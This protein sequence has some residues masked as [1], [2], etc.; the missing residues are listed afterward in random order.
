MKKKGAKKITDKKTISEKIIKEPEKVKADN[1]SK[2]YQEVY[3]NI[4]KEHEYLQITKPKTNQKDESDN[5]D[6]NLFKIEEKDFEQ[7]NNYYQNDP[8]KEENIINLNNKNEK[9]EDNNIND[10]QDIPDAT[11]NIFNINN[12]NL[13]KENEEEKY[14]D[15]NYSL[16]IPNI[17]DN[18][19]NININ[20]I[21]SQNEEEKEKFTDNIEYTSHEMQDFNYNNFEQ[22]NGYINQFYNGYYGYNNYYQLYQAQQNFLNMSTI[23][24]SN[25]NNRIK[26]DKD[27]NSI[28][29]QKIY[30][31]GPEYKREII[32]NDLKGNFLKESIDRY[33]NYLIKL[34]IEQEGKKN[35]IFKIRLIANELKG[36]FYKVSINNYGTRVVQALIQYIDEEG[37]KMIFDELISNEEFEKLFY[38][39]NGN[40]VMQNLIEKLNKNEVEQLFKRIITKIKEFCKK[41]YSCFVIQSLIEKCDTD[42]I[43]EIINKIKKDQLIN[44]NFGI[45]II[46]K[47]LSIYDENNNNFDINFI[48]KD[49]HNLNIYNKIFGNNVSVSCSACI[50]I[51]LIFEKG[52]KEE[53]EIMYK[54]LLKEKEKY[55][56]M[57]SGEYGNHVIQKIYCNSYDEIKNEIKNILNEVSEQN[58]NIY[59]NHVKNYIYENK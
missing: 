34:I 35:N 54:N 17:S 37:I 43:N 26:K 20:N 5:T 42:L 41:K 48:Y 56:L 13:S 57:F 16:N 32:F 3:K 29:L 10:Y 49:L 19:S 44:D 6:Q 40:H 9:N 23:N 25:M 47:L 1:S 50:I 45:H 4:P 8:D 18:I 7:N 24:Y 46:Q 27:I 39:K 53:K 55:I 21:N 51:E 31:I 33:K 58:K 36:S 38:D 14:N 59:F 11:E 30:E 2:E 22:V 52:K 15:I 12:N 28:N